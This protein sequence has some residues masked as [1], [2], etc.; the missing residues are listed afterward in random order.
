[1]ADRELIVKTIYEAAEKSFI[2]LLKEHPDED[3]YY[4]TI[5]SADEYVPCIS[6][7]S[8]ESWKHTVDRYRNE[9]EYL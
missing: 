6:A 3:F 4:F 2:G 1:M 8:Y 5:V 7:M 9:L